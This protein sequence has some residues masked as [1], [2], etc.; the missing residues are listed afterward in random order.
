MHHIN[1]RSVFVRPI[2]KRSALNVA[3]CERRIFSRKAR[4]FLHNEIVSS[5][6]GRRKRERE[7]AG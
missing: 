3:I 7:R 6:V 1:R 2:I 5:T 4:K